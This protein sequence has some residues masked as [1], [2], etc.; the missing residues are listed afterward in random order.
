MKAIGIVGSPRKG[1]NTEILVAHCL[2]A[3]AET[4]I[5]TELIRLAGLDIRGCNHCDY[6]HQ[7]K[8]EGFCSIKD[9]MQAVRVK[10]VA[11]DAII[12]GTPVYWGAATALVRGL[13]ERAAFCQ[14]AAF[15]G[16]VGGP[17]VVARRAGQ[18]FT[19]AE[20][21]FWFYLNGITTPAGTYWNM[22]VGWEK[23]SV[24]K[25]EE[26]MN[27]AWNFGKNVAKLAKQV[28]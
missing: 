13:M 10:M 9:D 24:T 15:A 27:T 2:K 16:K 17:I 21:N 25:D 26:G 1:G 28:R 7:P 5:E 4:G 19:F 12:I 8:H 20:M 6:C 23:G 11:A 22:A 18:N 14:R 3:I